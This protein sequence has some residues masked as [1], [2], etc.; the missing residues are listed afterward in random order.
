MWLKYYDEESPISFFYLLFY[1]VHTI[2]GCNRNR[3]R[4]SVRRMWKGILT[5]GEKTYK[6]AGYRTPLK[7]VNYQPRRGCGGTMLPLVSY[8]F[9]LA[10]IRLRPTGYAE[11]R[12]ADT[13]AREPLA[14]KRLGERVESYKV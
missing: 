14:C 12:R 9:E 13:S 1:F 3:Y 6:T 8:S 2:V 5:L 10:P 11:T 4:E 7:R